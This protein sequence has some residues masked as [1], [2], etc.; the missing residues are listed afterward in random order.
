MTG[1]TVQKFEPADSVSMADATA[2]VVERLTLTAFRCYDT[3]RIETGGRSVVLTGPNG[4]GKTNVLEAVSMLTPGRGLRRAKL[5][6]LARTVP[7]EASQG[8]WAVAA[9]VAGP[10]GTT[11]IGTGVAGGE[12]KRSVHIDGRAV[13]GQAALGEHLGAQWLTPA[14]DRLWV[15]GRSGRRRFLDRLVYNIDPAHAGRINAYDHAMRERARLLKHGGDADWIGVLEDTMAAKGAAV[16]A[17]RLDLVARLNR[18]CH[19]ADGPFPGAALTARGAVEGWLEDGDALDAEDRLKRELTASRRQDADTGGAQT[20]PHR[21]DLGC[22]HLPSGQAADLCSTG[23]QKA[24]LIAIVI[25]AA[26]MAAAECGRLPVLLLDEITAH[27]DAARRDGLFDMLTG[28]GAQIWTTGTE[29]ELF[30][31]LRERAC[32]VAVEDAT[33]TPQD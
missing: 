4:A 32:F 28:L 8:R 5:S 23:E 18:Y 27:L 14:M 3:A 11:D 20:G 6:E 30:D 16:A 10:L 12:D 9:T 25:A 26:R 13:R 21:S 7:G 15:E 31:G 2:S 1:A 29:P 24:L 19:D 22:V 17:A 33:L